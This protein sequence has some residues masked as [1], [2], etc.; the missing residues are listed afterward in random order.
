MKE[1]IKP[2]IIGII[3][4][5]LPYLF[6][7]SIKTWQWWPLMIISSFMIWFIIKVIKYIKK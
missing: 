3:A 4:G 6:G 5:T 7:Y 1:F 2:I